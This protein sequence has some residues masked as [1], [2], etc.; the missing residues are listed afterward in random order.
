MTISIGSISPHPPTEFN[1]S[2]V[3]RV[4]SSLTNKAREGVD[5]P[6]PMTETL[7]LVASAANVAALTSVAL[8]MNG[9]RSDRVQQLRHSIAS[10]TY[11]VEP[12]LVADVIMR[13]WQKKVGSKRH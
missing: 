12:N 11:K 7:T 4:T 1:E 6:P 3:D 13:D 10:G 8:S 9:V 5:A 2:P